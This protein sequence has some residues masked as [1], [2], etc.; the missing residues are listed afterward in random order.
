MVVQTLALT[1]AG[2]TDQW[3]GIYSD[4]N[5]AVMSDAAPNNKIP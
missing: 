3:D 2:T 4:I 5:Q 1:G